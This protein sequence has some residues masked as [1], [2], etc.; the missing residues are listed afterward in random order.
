MPTFGIYARR[1]PV[2]RQLL[3]CLALSSVLVLAVVCADADGPPAGLSSEAWISIQE[4]L[5]VERHRVVESDRPGRLWRADNPAQRFTAHFGAED[6]VIAGRGSSETSWKLGLRLTAWGAAHDLKQ[7]DFATATAEGNRVEYRR[8][9]LTEWYVNNTMGL[10]QGFT[11]EVPPG[12]D[13]EELVLEMTLEG[14]HTTVLS[15]GG[16]SV[17]FRRQ[18]TKTNLSYSGLAAW[19]AVGDV[20]E[21]RME[22]EANGTKL[23]LVISVAGASWPITV[24]PMFTQTAKLLPTPD[25]NT[26]GAFFGQ[27]IAVD[28]EVLVVGFRDQEHGDGSG[29]LHVFQRDQGGAP[30]GHIAKLTAAVPMP[31]DGVGWAVSIS[32]DTILSGGKDKAYVFQ[33]D[34]GGPDGWGLVAE[35][36]P[37]DTGHL[38]FG[39]S[40]SID[41][42]TAIVGDP[43]HTANGYYSGSVYVFQR[44]QGGPDAWGQVTMIVPD[45]VGE[46]DSFGYSVSISDG[47]AII[48]AIGDDEA[49]T[50]AGSAYVFQSDPSGWVQR[51]KI[52]SSDATAYGLFG[53]SVSISG[54]SAIVSSSPGSP[55]NLDLGFAYVFERDHN[56]PGAW[57]QVTRIRA[58]DINPDE[59]FAA[60]V[61]IDGDTAIVAAPNDNS[62]RINSVYVFMR[63]QGGTDA[64]GQTAKI[65]SSDTSFAFPGGAISLSGNNVAVGSPYVGD[66]FAWSGAAYVFERD[67]GGTGA[68]LEVEKLLCPPIFHASDDHFGYSVSLS[69]NTALVGAYG[70]DNGSGS[71]YI[72]QKDQ[73]GPNA[74]GLVVR[75][76]AADGSWWD[77]FGNSVAIDAD[78]AIIGAFLHDIDDSNVGAVYVFERDFGGLNLW[79]QV[80]KIVAP[81]GDREDLFGDSVAIDDDTILISATRDDDV[82]HDSG[83]AYF[84]QRDQGGLGAWVLAAK[85]CATDGG[86]DDDFGVSVSLDGDTAVIGADHNDD[87]GLDSGS[88]YIFQR[89]LGGPHNWGQFAKIA[90]SDASND[91]RF[92]KS[93]AISGDTVIVG[94]PG[95][96]DNGTNSGSVY[97]FQRDHGGLNAWGQV[98]KVTALDGGDDDSF[99][100]SVAIDVDTAIIGSSSDNNGTN[101]GSVYVHRRDFGGIDDWGQVAKVNASDGANGDVFGTSVCVSGSTAIIG[102]SGDD[103]LGDSSGSAYIFTISDAFFADGFETGDTSGWSVTVP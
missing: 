21:A 22:L 12:D 26:K 28:G 75:I 64:W 54:D 10:E 25:L 4:Q 79:G 73:G 3:S 13:I 7:V 6:V 17:I 16:N 101:S 56:G 74:W 90:A 96:D 57:G 60:S 67:Q 15:E 97:V 69:G 59:G 93:V 19:D 46:A 34:Q 51:A 41:G 53:I 87:H 94:S 76:T 89:D 85:V 18:D 27:S 31:D 1:G 80:A 77:S 32:G 23:H 71:A 47:K 8:G 65:T 62:G 14:N 42:D 52:I 83:S 99:G 58:D 11:I 20:L 102:A 40:V 82:D 70:D 24:D 61:S 103:D 68:W 29:A 48:G 45:D 30:W 9:A 66:D 5:E 36:T 100:K 55:S 63:N 91:D 39:K 72:F 37:S 49:G 35:I 92:G 78:T 38:S 81:D 95:D 98:A 2:S 84:F 88:A 50:N 43:G 33:R 86:R 44:D